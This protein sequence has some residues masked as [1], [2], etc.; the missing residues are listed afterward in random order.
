[1]K[2]L[3][4]LAAAS[5]LLAPLGSWGQNPAEIFRDADLK[6][7]ERLISEN[8]CAEC[9]VKKVGGDGSGI[10]RPTERVNTPGLLRGTV[11]QCNL[12]LNLALFPDEVTAISAVL[13]RDHY[14][15]K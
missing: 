8:R 4:T 3:L 10:Y 15:F 11:E 9:H 14:R 13:N 7:G 2:R 12:N 1:M 6:L 5:A